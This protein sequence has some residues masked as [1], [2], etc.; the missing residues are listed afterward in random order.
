VRKRIALMLAALCCLT[1]YGCIGGVAE[2]ALADISGWD[3]SACWDGFG[4]CYELF[5]DNQE[6]ILGGQSAVDALFP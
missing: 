1:T 6:M 3:L 4:T 5:S 2:W